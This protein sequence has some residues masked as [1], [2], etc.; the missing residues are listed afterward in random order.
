MPTSAP[1]IILPST[2][3]GWSIEAMVL[4]TPSTAATM[5]SAGSASAMLCIAWLGCISSSR[6]FLS[7]RAMTSSIWCGSSAFIPTMRR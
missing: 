4:I 1:P 5:P 7:S 2:A 3:G 6:I